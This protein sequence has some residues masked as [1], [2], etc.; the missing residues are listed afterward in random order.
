LS[1]H[2][3]GVRRR[4]AGGRAQLRQPGPRPRSGA[5]SERWLAQECR[6][7]CG[8]GV[9]GWQQLPGKPS[10]QRRIQTA[11]VA[12]VWQWQW[13][14]TTL[15]W[16][17]FIDVECRGG[18][19][20]GAVEDPHRPRAWREEDVA[21]ASTPALKGVAMSC[22]ED[23]SLLDGLYIGLMVAACGE[24]RVARAPHLIGRCPSV[25][26]DARCASRAK[27]SPTLALQL[28]FPGSSE[29]QV[30][31]IADSHPRYREARPRRIGLHPDAKTDTRT[32]GTGIPTWP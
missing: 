32:M 28:I 1:A 26:G 25:D 16:T 15:P 11:G 30:P 24:G 29:C 22:A 8:E 7:L 23:P 27:E 31:G 4:S 18:L 13:D 6:K 21:V 10:G 5:P 12:R 2:S 9:G 19:D 3:P 17:R 20:R 14:N